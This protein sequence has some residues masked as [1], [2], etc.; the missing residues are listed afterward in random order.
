MV[1]TFPVWSEIY[2]ASVRAPLSASCL[3]PCVIFLRPSYL[4]CDNIKLLAD[5]RAMRGR[6]GFVT[7]VP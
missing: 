3:A 7:T 5:M 1:Q 6:N 4:R 2:S